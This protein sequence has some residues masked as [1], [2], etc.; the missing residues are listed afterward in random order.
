MLEFVGYD[1][2]VFHL[3]SPF[4]YIFTWMFFGLIIIF[5]FLAFVIIFFYC[6]YKSSSIIY[7]LSC[8]SF[9][10]IFLAAF[11]NPELW[12]AMFCVSDF[13]FCIMHRDMFEMVVWGHQCIIFDLERSGEGSIEM[14]V[15]G[16]HC[17]IFDLEKS[18]ED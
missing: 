4:W 9:L 3:I 16:R 13:C 2:L 18:G 7:S 6:T 10:L 15:W 5:F 11:V 14:V 17:I 1:F 8:I 12:S